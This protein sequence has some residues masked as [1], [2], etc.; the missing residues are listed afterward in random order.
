MLLVFAITKARIWGTTNAWSLSQFAGADQ[1]N[2]VC[3]VELKIQGDDQNGTHL[4][5]SPAGYFTADSWHATKDD[6]LSS[7][8]E[9]FGVTRSTWT[10]SRSTN[11]G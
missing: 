6:A 9:L 7:A 4:V 8:F 3:V 10:N 11:T 1:P 2:C 5:M